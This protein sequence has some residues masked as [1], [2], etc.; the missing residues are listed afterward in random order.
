[1]GSRN[2]LIAVLLAVKAAM[3]WMSSA[4]IIAT[5]FA[6]TNPSGFVELVDGVEQRVKIKTREQR[7]SR[8]IIQK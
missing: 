1:S 3:D 8:R 5:G 4:W 6:G 2:E 7:N